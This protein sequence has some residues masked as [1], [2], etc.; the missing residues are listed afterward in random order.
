MQLVTILDDPSL[1]NGPLG[2]LFSLDLLKVLLH[3]TPKSSFA[4]VSADT[5]AAMTRWASERGCVVHHVPIEAGSKHNDYL[6]EFLKL[7]GA[8]EDEVVHAVDPVAA[9]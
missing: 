8:E 3:T 5:L 6:L 2:F 1:G 7:R 9:A 4:E